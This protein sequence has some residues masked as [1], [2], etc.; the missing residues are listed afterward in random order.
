MKLSFS[1]LLLLTLSACA[2]GWTDE[3]KKKLRDDCVEQTRTQISEEQTRKYCDCFVEQMVTTYPVF[4]DMMD[5]YK[6][7]T[8]E[9]LKAHC[10]H[11]IGL[12]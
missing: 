1:L 4:N 11:E 9:K 8:V 5:H 7:D 10:R 3:D 2:G 6:S 12:P